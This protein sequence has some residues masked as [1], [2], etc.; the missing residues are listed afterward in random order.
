MRQIFLNNFLRASYDVREPWRYDGGC[1]EI[2]GREG[3]RSACRVLRGAFA[4]TASLTS[5]SGAYAPPA[6][7][8]GPFDVFKVFYP[9]SRGIFEDEE[10]K[11]QREGVGG[12]TSR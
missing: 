12:S 3:H 8:F 4:T 1:W 11:V 7:R 9:L 6:L 5:K 2:R 10:V